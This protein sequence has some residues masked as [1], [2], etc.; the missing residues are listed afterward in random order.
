MSNPPKAT[1]VVIV[2]LFCAVVVFAIAG[3]GL[4]WTASADLHTH[5]EVQKS[6]MGHI[7]ESLDDIKVMQQADHLA[8]E[9][10]LRTVNG[11]P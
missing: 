10:I 1:I 11:V 7:K 5:E 6:E 2:T 3:G 9:K 4:G 8:I